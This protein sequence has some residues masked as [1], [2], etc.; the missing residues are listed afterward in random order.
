MRIQR[1]N[2]TTRFVVLPNETAQNHALSFTARGI[3]AYL[4]SLPD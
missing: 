4:V 1:S 3:L 2:P